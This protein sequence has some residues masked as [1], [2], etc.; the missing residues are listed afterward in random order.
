M[1]NQQ[2][3]CPFCP[4]TLSRGTGL[5]SHI[6][7]AHPKQYAG[8]TRSRKG[9]KKAGVSSS[10][11][12]PSE[13]TG[14]F[15]GIVVRLEQQRDAIDRALSALRDV[16]DAAAPSAPAAPVSAG[17]VEQRPAKKKRKG[18]LSPEGRA[19]LIAA[20]KKRWAA[21][22]AAEAAPVPTPAK[23]VRREVR[24]TPEGRQKLAEAMRR[25]WAVKRAASAVKKTA[26]KRRTAK[27]AA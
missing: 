13:L 27:K 1:P 5:A 23:A 19:R 17:P 7:G 20:L 26:R 14:G 4:K 15:H 11:S 16:E 3:Q 21:K 25:R 2:L 8:W 24:I 6:R 9:G 18:R 12:K 22:K 10:A